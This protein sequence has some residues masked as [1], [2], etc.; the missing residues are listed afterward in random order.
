MNL[1]QNNLSSKTRTFQKNVAPVRGKS[2]QGTRK[3]THHPAVAGFLGRR[4]QNQLG[5]AR[6][7]SMQGQRNSKTN[8]QILGNLK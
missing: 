6:G 7:S 4:Q 8:K 5:S 2:S 1:T 3:P